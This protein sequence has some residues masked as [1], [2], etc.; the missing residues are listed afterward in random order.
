MTANNMN[1]VDDEIFQNNGRQIAE[2]YNSLKMTKLLNRDLPGSKSKPAIGVA[3]AQNHHLN[4]QL[5]EM[6]FLK[7]ADN[8]FHGVNGPLYQQNIVTGQAIPWAKD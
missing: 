4:M 3:A 2:G 7:G 5:F 1:T 8:P 6:Q